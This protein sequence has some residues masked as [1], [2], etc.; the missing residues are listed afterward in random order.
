MRDPKDQRDYGLSFNKRF[1]VAPLAQ[2]FLELLTLIDDNLAVVGDGDGPALERARRGTFEIHPRNLEAAAVAGTVKFLLLV[3]PIG[4]A[5][6]VR[7]SRAQGI[8]D[9]AA[10]V[11]ILMADDPGALRLEA[12]DDFLRLILVGRADFELAGRLGENI[13]VQK[14]DGSDS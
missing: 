10:Q 1:R 8:N 5:A 2:F 6:Q 4:R 14:T 9:V 11:V 3:P 12:L 7:A 13:R